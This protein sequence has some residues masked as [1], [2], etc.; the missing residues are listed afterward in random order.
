MT[1]GKACMGLFFEDVPRTARRQAYDFAS[2]WLWREYEITAYATTGRGYSAWVTR[3]ELKPEHQQLYDKALAATLYEFLDLSARDINL[4]C[5]TD[6]F[7]ALRKVAQVSADSPLPV[8]VSAGR[9]L[10]AMTN[11]LMERM[12]LSK[13][14]GC[15]TR[16]E[17]ER[18][19]AQ[20]IQQAAI[21]GMAWAEGFA[22]ELG[23]YVATDQ[24][25]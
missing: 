14:V 2:T 15:T 20:E 21:A 16:A 6:G 25:F 8:L 10:A 13:Y 5:P 1:D 4:E 18:Q 9:D 11:T 23:D 12:Q 19:F 7:Y 24:I 17:F 22:G 3:D